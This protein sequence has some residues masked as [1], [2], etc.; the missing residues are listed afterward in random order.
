MKKEELREKVLSYI[1][2]ADD[3]TLRMVNEVIENYI[4]ND[5][6]A[7][8]MNG[9]PLCKEKYIKSIQAADASINKGEFTTVEDL[10]NE[11]GNW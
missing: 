6:V 10:E 9:E 7:Y 4:T 5:I 8:S 3:D 11:V 1:R 2:E